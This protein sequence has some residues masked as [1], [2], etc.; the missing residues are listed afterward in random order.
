M[1][2]PD[3]DSISLI[4]LCRRTLQKFQERYTQVLR[5]HP[6]LLEKVEALSAATQFDSEGERIL[7]AAQRRYGL[8]PRSDM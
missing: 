5:A 6:Q 7:E 2:V 4:L 8:L 1:P 3:C